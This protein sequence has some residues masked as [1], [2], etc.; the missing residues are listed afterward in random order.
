MKRGSPIMS[1]PFCYFSDKIIEAPRS[2]NKAGQEMRSLW[3]V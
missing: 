1:E 2:P 3:N